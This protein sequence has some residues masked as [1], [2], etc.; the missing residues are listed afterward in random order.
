[1]LVDPEAGDDSE[2][3][4]ENS[5]VS[6]ARPEYYR[7]IDLGPTNEA[8][9]RMSQN[10]V[11]QEEQQN[12]DLPVPPVRTGLAQRRALDRELETQAGR[13]RDAV[14][15]KLEDYR[16]R[17]GRARLS[18]EYTMQLDFQRSTGRAMFSSSAAATVPA[19]TVSAVLAEPLLD[20][21]ASAE[22]LAD[23]DEQ[24]QATALDPAC[25]APDLDG[26]V[27]PDL[28]G[29]LSARNLDF[30]LTQLVP[31]APIVAEL[32]PAPPPPRARRP[33][34]KIIEFPRLFAMEPR[35]AMSDELAE[36]MIDRPR[37][38]DV[39][40][41]MDQI[42]L[43]LGDIRLEAAAARENNR[44][45]ELETPLQV[46][47]VTQRFCAGLADWIMV[48]TGTALF[49]ATV[50]WIVKSFP[51]GKLVVAAGLAVPCV[52]WA[53]YHY[54][55]LVHAAATPGMHIA[56]LRLATFD[57]RCTNRQVRR[58][59]ALAMFL[60]CASAGLGFGWALVDEDTLCW[61]DRI[62][63]TYVTKR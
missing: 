50:L 55:F 40:E 9:E 35:D 56:Q 10:V 21:P 17:R 20:E 6:S 28:A 13:W 36:S 46:A 57:G 11:Q 61:H 42:E 47:T 7:S 58:S 60:S 23:Y 30:Q 53:L 2:D 12:H 31:E 8:A 59:R 15:D 5:L 26:A 48:L 38:M 19:L 52:F 29:K 22:H 39:P 1:M 49:A 18:G 41:E 44:A 45:P 24:A 54:L 4:F 33:Q 34:P 25:V 32:A 16:S 14:G 43:P 27:A 63:R 37:I 3:Q 51:Q 62:S